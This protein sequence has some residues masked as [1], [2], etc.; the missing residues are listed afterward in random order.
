MKKSS[1]FLLIL[2]L[3]SISFIE[4]L[5]LNEDIN[6]NFTIFSHTEKGSLISTGKS[7]FSWENNGTPICTRSG[8]QEH[9][10]I[11][12]DESGGAIIAWTDGDIYAQRINSTGHIQWRLM[13]LQYVLKFKPKQ[14][15]V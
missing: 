5:N 2:L 9:P 3:F 11:C 12:S 15:F 1:L 8:S 4:V 7:Y 6:L 10:R 14:M 13:E